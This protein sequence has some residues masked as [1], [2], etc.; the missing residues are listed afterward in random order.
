[1]MAVLG[2]F[3]YLAIIA[4]QVSPPAQLCD[5][6]TTSLYHYFAATDARV[7]GGPPV[8]YPE[9]VTVSPSGSVAVADRYDYDVKIYDRKGSHLFTYGARGRGPGGILGPV[10]AAFLDDTLLAV[11][12]DGQQM[13]HLVNIRS[14]HSNTLAFPFRPIGG[15]ARMSE[16]ELLVGAIGVWSEADDGH[17]EALGSVHK[18]AVERDGAVSLR[19]LRT[20]IPPPARLQN[21]IAFRSFWTPLTAAS[22][23]GS[24]LLLT[25]RLTDEIVLLNTK[26]MTVSRRRELEIPGFKPLSRLARAGQEVTGEEPLA[27]ATPVLSVA[28]TGDH[29]LLGYILDPTGQAVLRY[30]LF[31]GDL[32]LIAADLKGPRVFS[33]QLRHMISISS[34]STG[35][36][37]LSYLRSCDR[38]KR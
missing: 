12:D 1:M 36:S 27:L 4:S 18:I 38:T 11:A 13:L 21:K 30:A 15:L 34:D 5:P 8:I 24:T 16:E 2:M 29:V 32:H 7:L 33:G 26:S 17:D 19:I 6:D 22:P 28:Y 35:A 14:Q 20:L 3:G 25:W 9:N 23:D 31:D 37:T 10:W